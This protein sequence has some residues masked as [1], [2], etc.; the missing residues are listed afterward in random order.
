M[1][2]PSLSQRQSL[3]MVAGFVLCAWVPIHASAKSEPT[4]AQTPE[5]IDQISDAD[6]GQK[7]TRTRIFL[8]PQF[9]PAYPGSD[10]RNMGPYLDFSRARNGEFFAFEAPDESFGFN[11]YEKKGSAFGLAAHV[12]GKRKASD[13]DGFLPQ[14]KH[15]VELGVGAQSWIT[16]NVR[17]RAELRKAVTGHKAFVGNISADYVIQRGDDWLVS[18]GPRVTLADS[19]YHRAY[20][21]VRASDAVPASQ[22]IPYR[23]KGGLHS[24]GVAASVLYQLNDNWGLAGFAK[25]DHLF[26][27]AASSPVTREYGSRNQPSAGLAVSYTFNSNR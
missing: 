14:V 23:P 21:G 2:P 6:T 1:L 20:Y 25:Y 26:G 17:L 3:F 24:A 13:T 18:I 4:T 11:V 9:G 15:S 8:G 16:P 19:K 22:L 10:R 7:P 27:D 5:Q 12:Q